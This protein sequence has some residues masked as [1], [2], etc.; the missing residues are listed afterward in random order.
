MYNKKIL[1]RKGSINKKLI[2]ISIRLIIRDNM[3]D[4][5]GFLFISLV[6]T[7]LHFVYDWSNH[8]EY[9]SIFSAVNESVWE[10]MKLVV[11][12]SLVWLLIEIPFIGNNH[13]FIIAKCISLIVMVLFIP[14]IFY[15]FKYLFKKIPFFVDILIFYVAVGLGQYLSDVILNK[16]GVSPVYNY[17][18]LIILIGIYGY[19]L[20]ATFLPGKGEIYVDPNTKKKGIQGHR[21][22]K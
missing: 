2:N 14:T 19:F 10:H 1:N 18:S 7:I 21:F 4:F 3:I 16:P 6:G 5:Y 8:N 22:F 12:P 15:L 13:N 9:A 20:I 17:L 11:F